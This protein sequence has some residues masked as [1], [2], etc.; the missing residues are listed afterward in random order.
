MPPK[1]ILFYKTDRVNERAEAIL[2]RESAAGRMDILGVSAPERSAVPAARQ[3]LPFFPPEALSETAFDYV[4][5]TDEGSA[6]RRAGKRSRVKRLLP[7]FLLQAYYRLSAKLFARKKLRL[8][9]SYDGWGRPIARRPDMVFPER[10][11]L[12]AW[13]VPAE[14][15]IPARTLLLP[16]FRMD[17]YAALRA[18][19]LTLV[20]DNCWG[21]LMY[22]TLGLELSS[23]FVNMFVHTDE[24][25]RLVSDLPHYLAQPLVPERLCTRRGGAVVYPVVKLGD[26]HLFFN[27]VTTPAEL[28]VYAE[29]WYRRRERMDLEHVLVESSFNTPE[30]EARFAPL[31]AACPYPKLV[32]APYETENAV[33]LRA[34]AD[35]PGRYKGDFPECTRDAA[36]NEYPGELP[37]DLLQTLLTGTVQPPK[38]ES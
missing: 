13:G 21:G 1:C 36:K 29:K 19:G 16:G 15:L 24:F 35:D 8:W 9:K 3:A 12:A 31:L 2:A 20:S 14:K 18:R 7:E 10:G 25:A 37:L 6:E 32:F 4:F 33:C 38:P 28:E 30:E 17:E 26:V 23:P 34:F 11:A 22:H 27:H 5:V